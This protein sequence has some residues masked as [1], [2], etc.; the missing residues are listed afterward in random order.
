MIDFNL[1]RPVGVLPIPIS[2]TMLKM[3]E[4]VFI[5][6]FFLILSFGI[7]FA[8]NKYA[9]AHWQQDSMINLYVPV[10]VSGLMYF[11]FGLSLTLIKGLILLFILLFASNS[12]I[13]KREVTDFVP[14]AIL[15]TGFINIEF[16]HLPFM[17]LSAVILTLPQLIVAVLN[18]GSYG[19]A[20]LKIM[21]ASCLLLSLGKGLF[22]IIVGLLIAVVSTVI[23]RKIKKESL[24]K[25]FPLVP[26]LSIGV[27]LAY[28]M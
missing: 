7:G 11:R 15:I 20:D 5:C 19:G 21:A 14:I 17:L 6:F 8:V 1:I 26:Y 28:L 2:D 18:P 24:K 9:K 3:F 27:I 22:A 10:I 23:I 13:K 16:N 4:P 25:S 12:D